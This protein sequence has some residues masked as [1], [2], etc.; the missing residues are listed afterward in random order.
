[1]IMP[2]SPYIPEKC[3]ILKIYPETND[4]ATFR[5]EYD[6]DPQPGEFVEVGVLGIGEAPI[7]ICSHSKKF[8]DLCIRNVGNVTR[9]IHSKKAKEYVWIRGPYGHGY[10]MGD[11][12]GKDI[13]LAGG[14]TGV[15]PLKGAIEYINKHRSDFGKVSIFFGFRNDEAILFKDYFDGWKRDFDFQLTLD[16]PSDKI[17]CNVGVVTTLID[18]AELN[19]DAIAIMC[20]PPVMIKF[21]MQSLMKKGLNEGNVYIS[22]ERLMSCGIGKC[23]HCEVG[24][25]YVC[26]HGPVF[27]YDRAKDMAD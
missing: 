24:G 4:T 10:P 21:M 8:V 6:G 20:G 5:I 7:S 18:K 12:K 19:K 11:F 13:I 14:G 16:C 25:K 15:A 22:F 17:K 2:E 9:S 1:M 3:R 27:R 23:G 26:R